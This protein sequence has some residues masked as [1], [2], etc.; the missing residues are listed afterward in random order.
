MNDG[1]D[2]KDM[3]PLATMNVSE[4]ML[5]DNEDYQPDCPWKTFDN[6][7]NDKPRRNL[8]RVSHGKDDWDDRGIKG[9]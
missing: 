2:P 6:N 8:N 7:D 3:P 9:V 5:V 1:T 4:I